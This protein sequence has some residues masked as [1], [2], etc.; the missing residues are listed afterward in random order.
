MRYLIR[1]IHPIERATSEHLYLALRKGS[2][3]LPVTSLRCET[4]AIDL[5]ESRNMQVTRL[6]A[7]GIAGIALLAGAACSDSPGSSSPEE[8]ATREATAAPSS[9]GTTVSKTTNELS[10][11]DLVKLV[12]PSI[13]RIETNSG[14]G[15]GFVVDSD[16]YILTNNHVILSAA[17]RAAA[18]IR[19]TLSDGSVATAT[20][21]GADPRSDLALIK[22]DRGGLKALPFADLDNVVIGQ[23]VVAVGYALDLGLGEGASFSVTRGIVSQKNR[24]INEGGAASIFGAI[25]TDAAINHGNSGGPLLNMFGEVVGINTALAPGEQTTGIGF[26]VGS[27]VAKAVYEAI[28]AD[29]RVN[30]GFLGIGQFE[31]LRSAKA[32]E[33]NIPEDQKGIVIGTVSAGGPA[34]AGGLQ[35]GDVLVK[36]GDTEIGSEADLTVALVRQ[37]AGETVTVE[38]FRGSKKQS[39]E[40]TLGTPAA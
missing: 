21:V 11:A 22:I 5:V 38:Y 14:V 3:H 2:L 4:L 27:D 25:Q 23:D 24:A 17:G 37:G 40:V 13:V 8:P 1:I 35:A 18:N 36:L 29:G 19:V 6:L 28:K 9:Q 34:A 16:G 10:T 32:K 33:L 20:V 12:E 7:A 39:A 15:S 30:R 26:A 31:A